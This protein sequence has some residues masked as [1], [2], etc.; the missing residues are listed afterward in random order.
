MSAAVQSSPLDTAGRIDWGRIVAGAFLVELVLF[1]VLIPIGIVV[2]PAGGAMTDS[3]IFLM[4]VPIGLF[5]LG[6]AVTAWILRRVAARRLLH[7]TLIGIVA[8]L[9]Y[10]GLCAVQPGGVAAVIAGYGPPLFWL[11]QALR[12]GGCAAGAAWTRPR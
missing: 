5:V 11:S 3:T 12:V 2:M 10:F 6:A 9:I 8:T 1:V 4:S 7:G